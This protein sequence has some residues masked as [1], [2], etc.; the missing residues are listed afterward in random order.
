M[1]IYELYTEG[2]LEH[3]SNI[4]MIIKPIGTILEL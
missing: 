3:D 4:Q 2:G 1:I